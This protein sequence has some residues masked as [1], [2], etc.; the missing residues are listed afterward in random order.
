MFSCTILWFIISHNTYFRLPPFFVFW[1]LYFTG[2]VAIYLRCGKIVKYEFVANSPVRPSVKKFWKSVYIWGS[3]GQEFGVLFFN[4]LC[5]YHYP[6]KRR[7]SRWKLSHELN[8]KLNSLQILCYSLCN[9]HVW[10]WPVVKDKHIKIKPRIFI[11][12]RLT[13]TVNA[14]PLKTKHYSD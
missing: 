9:V 10:K 1:R 3:Y 4:S 6:H 13:W 7:H 2:S 11:L 5:S 12:F 8:G 14:N